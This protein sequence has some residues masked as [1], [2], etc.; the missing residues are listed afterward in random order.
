MMDITI[1]L[2]MIVSLVQI[3]PSIV[4]H[5]CK[6]SNICVYGAGILVLRVQGQ[7]W[8][9][10]RFKVTVICTVNPLFINQGLSLKFHGR[11]FT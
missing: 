3:G 9:Q 7:S 10:S 5:A 4:V 8:I 11:A 6:P 2:I 1:I